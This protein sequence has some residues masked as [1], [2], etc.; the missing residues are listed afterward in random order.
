MGTGGL[1]P[2]DLEPATFKRALTN[3]DPNLDGPIIDVV[4]L[5]SGVSDAAG[6]AS[7]QR[8]VPFNAFAYGSS[9]SL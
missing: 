2:T 8:I 3:P 6:R 4:R 7:L 5:K 9:N 1:I